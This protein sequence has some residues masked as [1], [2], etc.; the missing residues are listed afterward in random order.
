[1]LSVVVRD[2][3]SWEEEGGQIVRCSQ[4]WSDLQLKMQRRL[5]EVS[6]GSGEDEWAEM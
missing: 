5:E 2:Q 3:T 1:M 6:D 4:I